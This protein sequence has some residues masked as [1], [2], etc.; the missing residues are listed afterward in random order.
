M[1]IG[2][3]GEPVVLIRDF[4][5]VELPPNLSTE[6]GAVVEGTLAA[7]LAGAHAPGQYAAAGDGA[8]APPASPPIL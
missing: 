2:K 6:S 5:A 3:E 7:H 1:L 4:F 8:E